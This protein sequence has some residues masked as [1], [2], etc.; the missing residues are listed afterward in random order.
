MSTYI[1]A[2]TGASGS[3]YAKTLLNE[4][5]N[6]GHQIY[7]VIS[8]A[9]RQV[10][11]TELG[12]VL[13]DSPKLIE[14][15]LKEYLGYEPQSQSLK[16]FHHTEIGCLIASGS[17][18]NQGMIVI[19]C[20]M[21]TLSGIAVGRSS[22]LIERAADIMLKE[23]RPLVIVPRETPLNQIHLKNMLTLAQM[24]VRIVPAMPAFYN[25]PESIQDLVNF[26]VGRAMDGLG[27]EHSLYQP[28]QG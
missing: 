5:K 13:P 3:I 27:I 24:G 23:G 20:S 16:Y 15:V 2:I 8:E 12:W 19:P 1:V 11:A 4:L 18:K 22:N 6:Q 9:G 28:W 7:L 21:S 25:G 26:V 14:E 10:L 17:A